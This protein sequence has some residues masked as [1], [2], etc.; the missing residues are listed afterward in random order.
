MVA[1]VFGGNSVNNALFANEYRKLVS[2]KKA[3]ITIPA[4]LS[5]TGTVVR[6]VRNTGDLTTTINLPAAVTGGS[7]T[8]DLEQAV[9]AIK[10]GNASGPFLDEGYGLIVYPIV[11]PTCNAANEEIVKIKY[12]MAGNFNYNGVD[13][14]DAP[15]TELAEISTIHYTGQNG[16][17]TTITQP[18]A[19]VPSN[20][21]RWIVQLTDI[22]GYRQLENLWLGQSAAGT[23]AGTNIVSI[24]QVTDITGNTTTGAPLVNVNGVFQLGSFPA[25]ANRYYLVSA[26][27]D[28]C[29]PVALNLFRGFDCAGYPSTVDAASCGKTLGIL[30]YTPAYSALQTQIIAQNAGSYRPALCENLPYEVEVNNAGIGN[31]SNLSIR[32][33]L[34]SSGGLSYVPGSL[35]ITPKFVG[36][37]PSYAPLA[38]TQVAISASEIVITIPA[39]NVDYL[40]TGQRYRIKLQLT[41]QGCNFKSGQRISF[42]GLGFDDCEGIVVSATSA[43]SNRVTINGS[44][45]TMPNLK[46]TLSSAT[47][48]LTT[49]GTDLTAKYNFTLKN[50]DDGSGNSYPATTAYFFNIKLPAGW[51]FTDPTVL[52]PSSKATYVGLDPVKGYIFQLASDLL[53]NQEINII[54]A[55]L[56]Y[57]NASSLACNY[58]SLPIYESAYTTFTPVSVCPG[59]PCNIDELTVEN[60]TTVLNAPAPG[61]PS[62]NASQTF[63]SSANPT[64]ADIVLTNQGVL[65]WY[66]SAASTTALPVS[67]P[68]VNGQTY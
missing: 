42:R 38:D 20:K 23:T 2:P 57:A 16:L 53:I 24:Q 10:G 50:T 39:A 36:G 26:D 62:G 43:S 48:N 63:C 34:P 60:E 40:Q 5:S 22:L 65:V 56:V 17:V 18:I 1:Y 29:A 6:L 19:A 44:P 4:G 33:P 59:T 3:T 68:L 51:A 27:Y 28:G 7:Y 15:E 45:S 32:I 47:V 64:L 13:Y 41:T 67:T 61:A 11:T 9:A 58:T 14:L 12:A 46:I 25:G 37:V 52:V 55:S 66:S 31:A 8:V 21:A 49:S 30:T 35:Q 54:D